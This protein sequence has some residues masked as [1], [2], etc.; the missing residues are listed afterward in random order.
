MRHVGVGNKGEIDPVEVAHAE[1]PIFLDC[2]APP[3]IYTSYIAGVD[4]RRP[5]RAAYAEVRENNFP[6]CLHAA[7]RQQIGLD[8]QHFSPCLCS[9]GSINPRLNV[10]SQQFPSFSLPIHLLSLKHTTA[11]SSISTQR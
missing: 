5:I 11:E 10:H 7:A 8:N 6:M 1:L 3:Q 9:C 2:P 4:P